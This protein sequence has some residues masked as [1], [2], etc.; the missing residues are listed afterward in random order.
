MIVLALDLR[1][2]AP[3]LSLERLVFMRQNFHGLL[4][5]EEVL[6]VVLDESAN[7]VLSAAA[8]CQPCAEPRNNRREAIFLNKIEQPLLAAEIV[9]HSGEG[10]AGCARDVAH[11]SALVAFFAEDSC[12]AFED[13]SKLLVKARPI[14]RN[15]ILGSV[16][17]ES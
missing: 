3:V 7:S 11:G 1:D 13:L 16:H 6:Q 5:L 14:G 2:F 10:H 17:F 8:F 4:M 15:V 9:V 12:G